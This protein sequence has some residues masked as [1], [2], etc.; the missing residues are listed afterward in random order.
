MSRYRFS[1]GLFLA[2]TPAGAYLAASRPGEDVVRRVLLRLLGRARTPPLDAGGVARLAGIPEADAGELVQR[3]QSLAL[4]QGLPQS[5]EAPVAAFETLIPPL[6]ERL[7]AAGR[8]VLADSQGFY[9][10]TSGFPHEAAEELSALGAGLSRIHERHASLLRGN[11]SMQATAW[12]LVDASG[13]SQLGFWPLHLGAHEFVLA[14]A[15]VPR[16][17]SPEF[18]TLAWALTRRYA[19]DNEP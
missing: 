8:C 1:E 18:V 2:P 16:F 6:L 14:I 11:L 9:L 7:S 3:M 19:P 5:R 17:N 13:N 10:A 12:G 4:V 15:G